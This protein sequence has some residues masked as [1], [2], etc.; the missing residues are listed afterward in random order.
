MAK[1]ANNLRSAL[2][3][4]DPADD[5]PMA[6]D[7][8]HD[9]DPLV[10]LARIVSG[11]PLYPKADA[12]GDSPV[13]G[14]PFAPTTSAGEP[15]EAMGAAA[16]TVADLHSPAVAEASVPAQEP[17]VADVTT[18]LEQELYAEFAEPEMDQQ[19]PRLPMFELA[20]SVFEDKAE[21][22][23]ETVAEYDEQAGEDEKFSEADP[24]VMDFLPEPVSPPAVDRPEAFSDPEAAAD[25]PATDAVEAALRDDEV[26]DAAETATQPVYE[27]IAPEASPAAGEAPSLEDIMRR[28][29]A[30]T[31]PA[32]DDFSSL[33]DDD[34]FKPD[35]SSP[36]ATPGDSV[37][38]LSQLRRNFTLEN[39]DSRPSEL[40]LTPPVPAPEST[41]EATEPEIAAV[42][43]IPSVNEP[44]PEPFEE[45]VTEDADD[46]HSVDVLDDSVFEASIRAELAADVD[47]TEAAI[48]A[49][50]PP[51][52]ELDAA[53]TAD[54]DDP[55]AAALANAVD[56]AVSKD[57]EQLLDDGVEDAPAG[58]DDFGPFAHDD[59]DT[60]SAEFGSFEPDPV[61]SEPPV[62]AAGIEPVET[63]EDIRQAFDDDLLDE[64]HFR[65]AEPRFEDA[66]A[67]Q[68]SSEFD[69][70]E[71]YQSGGTDRV[72]GDDQ[73]DG[74]AADGDE[75]DLRAGEPE[76][77]GEPFADDEHI[78]TDDELEPPRVAVDLDEAYA[79]R[80]VGYADVPQ[81]QGEYAYQDDYDLNR[82]VAEAAYEAE[83][84]YTDEGMLPPHTDEELAASPVEG[85]GSRGVYAAMVLGGAVVIGLG[86]FFGYRF[87][88]GEGQSGPPPL[89]LA[90]TSPVKVKPEPTAGGD[91]ASRSKLIYDRV[92]GSD[93]NPGEE[94]LVI[95]SEDPVDP[96]AISAGNGQAGADGSNA[97]DRPVLPRRVR[98]V[99][100]RPD[101]TIIRE[102]PQTTQTAAATP[103]DDVPLPGAAAEEAPAP[104]AEDIDPL[105]GDAAPRPGANIPRPKPGSQAALAASAAQPGGTAA[106]ATARAEMPAATD[107]ADLKLKPVDDAADTASGNSAASDAR[108]VKTQP[109]KVTSNNASTPAERPAEPAAA[110]PKASAPKV[111]KVTTKPVRT[112]PTRTATK[113]KTNSGP[114]DLTKPAPAASAPASAPAATTQAPAA[115][116][117]SVQLS[118]QRTEA[119]AQAAYKAMQRRHPALLSSRNAMILRADLGAKGTYYRVRV[120]PMS[121]ADANK[122]CGDLKKQGGDCFTRRN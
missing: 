99:V 111:K 117:Y 34:R 56:D 44:Q 88:A 114:L 18:E 58:V 113:P 120:G 35:G 39:T 65:R 110:A 16:E 54:M 122:F 73:I 90:D 12:D 106:P 11:G 121:R 89:I 43:P 63:P 107:S 83:P 109:V 108:K 20:P 50:L 66:T 37:S 2:E 19:T 105:A 22:A 85:K 103:A 62:L 55:I 79:A 3:R 98:T 78:E 69:G 40:D 29:L 6:V 95:R 92:G 10:E 77:G 15:V 57:L 53:E 36:A 91:E 59:A 60:V 9:E 81:D 52:D 112:T 1:K 86:A 72:V 47:A 31:E 8:S 104:A 71:P 116:T 41:P 94:R 96:R 30:A 38:L 24:A 68:Q 102:T 70:S 27:D 84:G 76:F 42:E 67:Y 75:H 28:N 82:D 119:Q 33:L 51:I 4:V 49:D 17:V 93:A 118:S 5:R 32:Q 25:E 74:Y 115:G 7:R 21:S 61:V 26:M 13:T 46:G 101:G 97:A 45:Q 100:V 64:S 23:P 87:M 48:E 14:D 80:D